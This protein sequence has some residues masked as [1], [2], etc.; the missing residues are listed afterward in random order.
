MKIQEYCNIS[1]KGGNPYPFVNAI[2]ESPLPCY[3]QY[4]KGD[5]FFFQVRRQDLPEL[6]EIAKYYRM[7][8]T[9]EEVPSLLGRLKR[10]RFRFGLII[11]LILGICLI[12]Y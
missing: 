9:V 10:Y 1:A 7:E 8:L 12:F 11:G 2:R 6:R 3:R 4:C 5:T